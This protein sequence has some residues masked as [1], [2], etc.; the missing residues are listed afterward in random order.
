LKKFCFVI[1]C[2]LFLT[3]CGKKQED[4][5]QPALNF[6][7]TV[8][9]HGGCIYEADI[10]ADFGDHAYVFTLA[11]DYTPGQQANFTVLQPQSIAGIG[12]TVSAL[13]DRIVFDG[14]DLD[15]GQLA[16]GYVVPLEMPWLLGQCWTEEYIASVGK[17]GEYTLITYLHG[18]DDGEVTVET[19]LDKNGIPVQSDVTYDGRRCVTVCIRDFRYKELVP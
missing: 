13:G 9:K 15:F 3:A 10:T 7:T 19:W 2:L 14:V 12:G 16:N 1:L 5:R 18:Y 6:R 17:D 11:C 8:M 4:I